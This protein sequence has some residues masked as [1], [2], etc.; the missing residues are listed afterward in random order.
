MPLPIPPVRAI[1]RMVGIMREVNLRLANAQEHPKTGGVNPTPS[2][3]GRPA[4][5]AKKK[6][7]EALGAR[8][9]GAKTV[10]EKRAAGRGDKVI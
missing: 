7:P 9:G 8:F 10:P 5:G 3:A 2:S 1:E 6:S 4:A